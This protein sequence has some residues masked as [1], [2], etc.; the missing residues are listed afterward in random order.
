MKNF[1]CVL[2][3]ML[4]V[5]A[6]LHAGPDPPLTQ[7]NGFTVEA[8]DVVSTDMAFDGFDFTVIA[9]TV[10]QQEVSTESL[11]FMGNAEALPGREPRVE[12]K[13][14]YVERQ[15]NSLLYFGKTE[16][17]KPDANNWAFRRARDGLR[18]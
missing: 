17:T 8:V 12:G 2:I 4:G 13:N 11:P 10:F 15:D 1:F 7:D 5:F 9:T 3:L 6:M 16:S 14:Y 18:Q